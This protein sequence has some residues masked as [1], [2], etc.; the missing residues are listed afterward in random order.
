MEE[1]RV[2]M[3]ERTSEEQAMYDRQI[4]TCRPIVIKDGAWIG[5]GATLLPGVTIGRS[6]IIGAASV[7]THDVG[8]YEVAVGSPARIIKKLDPEKFKKAERE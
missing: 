5:A 6:A 3:R 4:L 7:V 8:D 1:V 2:D